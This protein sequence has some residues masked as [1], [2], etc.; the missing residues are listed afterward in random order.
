MRTSLIAAAAS[1]FL[2]AAGPLPQVTN[3]EAKPVAAPYDTQADAH[4]AVDA[5]FAAA[6][7]SGRKV[8]IDLGGNWCPDCRALAGVLASPQVKPW[9]DQG[10]VTVLVDVGRFKKNLDIAE[11]Y[12]VKINAAPTVLIITPDGKLLNKDAVFA[13]ADARS[14][15]AQAV[16]DLLAGWEKS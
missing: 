6:R 12:G 8:M 4:A 3:D 9:V 7:A 2:A 14:M 15:S 11:K 13:L 10:F 1:L 5:A 16:V